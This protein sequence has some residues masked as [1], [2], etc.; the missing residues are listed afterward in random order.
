MKYKAS[1]CS[2]KGPQDHEDN[3]FL[4]PLKWGHLLPLLIENND[5][6]CQMFVRLFPWR[7]SGCTC[8]S[9]SNMA[10]AL[11]YLC[12]PM[13]AKY[14]RKL[15]S[16][17]KYLLSPPSRVASIGCQAGF[18]WYRIFPSLWVEFTHFRLTLDFEGACDSASQ[19]LFLFRPSLIGKV[20]GLSK[21]RE[22]RSLLTHSWPL[23]CADRKEGLIQSNQPA[24]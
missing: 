2:T 7:G 11:D 3:I 24:K 18:L 19:L 6:V 16:D 20:K 4:T 9:A 13:R 5:S 10:L 21:G 12:T 23:H 17:K 15:L 8:T 22:A 14:P 1:K